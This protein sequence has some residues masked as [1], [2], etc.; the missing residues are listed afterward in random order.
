VSISAVPSS[1]MALSLSLSQ[2][3]DSVAV[4]SAASQADSAV[5][6]QGVIAAS[7]GTSP[8]A[9]APPVPT[10]QAY[11]STGGLSSAVVVGNALN[12]SV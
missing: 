11:S 10:V 8:T 1:L 9:S 3:Q 5:S 2:M 6:S 7:L 4:I 12:I